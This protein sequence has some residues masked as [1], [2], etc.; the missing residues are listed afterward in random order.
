MSALSA[1]SASST[2]SSLAS[3]TLSVQGL[4]SGLDTNKI[5]QGLLAIDQAKITAIDNKV[6]TLQTQQTAYKTL[7][8]RLLALQ[9]QMTQLSRSQNGIFDSRTVQSSNEDLVTAAASSSAVPGVYHF[10]VNSLAAAQQIASQGFDSAA[11][12]VTD[13]TLQITVGSA[14]KTITI[15]S[16]NDTLQGLADAI[17]AAD[18]GATAFVVNDGSGDGKEGNRLLLVANQAGTANKISIVNNLADSSGAAVKPIFDTAQIGAARNASLDTGTATATSNGGTAYTGTSNNTY[19]FTVVQGGT[20]G[21]DDNLQLSY[22][23]ATGAHTGTITLNASDAGV[24]KD[25][26]EGVQIQF[27]AGTLVAGDSY[28][29]KT[30]VPNVQNASD[31]SV[32]L[33]SGAGALTVNSATNQ[34]NSLIP[35]VTLQLQ[36]ADPTKDVTLTVAADTSKIK[37]TIT[38][39][40]SSFNDT[41]DFINQQISYDT[42]SGKAGPLLGDRQVLSIQQQLQTA[43]NDVIPGA[44][45]LLNHLGA[46]GITMDD[47]G[48]LVVDD[49]KLTNVL[50]GGKTGVSLGDVRRLFSLSGS[51]P[52]N[53]VQFIT[54]STKTI[55]SSTPYV[56][57]ITQA[58]AR[59]SL[60]AATA[61]AA[62]TVIDN[63][64]NTFAI[65]LDGATSATLTLAA[66]TYSQQALAQA[67]QAAINSDSTLQGRGVTASLTGGIL[68]LT[69]NRYGAASNVTAKSGTALAALGFTAGASN[70]GADVA[71]SYLV[72]GVTETAVGNGQ[73]LLGDSNNSNTADL[74]V[75]V[76]LTPAQVGAGVD[77]DLNVSRGVASRLDL[78]LT[79]LF[80]PVNGR[81]KQI[82]DDF[83]TSISSLNDQKSQQTEIMQARQASLEEQFTAMEETL[84]QLQSTSNFLALQTAN[85]TQKK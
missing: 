57:H 67:V 74:Q 37:T 40:V 60:T 65:G 2:I 9:G 52:N 51:S 3:G 54:G 68:T 46:L 50:T 55:A 34:V 17:N 32:T 42:T 43:M 33:G 30:F 11:S 80:D 22:T 73:F 84:S 6:S 72:N 25:A 70:Q 20:V 63:T 69:S 66:G 78:S 15:D 31:A 24:F 61:L 29:I 82:D 41:I 83:N 28:T 13:G 10:R 75:R 21:A 1:T 8:A 48:K 16:T 19:T 59:A 39:F 64:N 27:G 71:G 36:A 81:L 47:N 38:D 7:E 49:A 45:P 4:V 58:A 12:N 53:G 18:A 26:A 85:T 56:V 62:S 79:S 76:T 44:N 14:T 5:I 23:D 77:A 35:G